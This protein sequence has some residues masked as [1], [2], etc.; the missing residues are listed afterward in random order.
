MLDKTDADMTGVASTAATACVP[1]VLCGTALGTLYI[2]KNVQ[3]GS[4]DPAFAR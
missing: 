3:R 2:G 4:T 1:P